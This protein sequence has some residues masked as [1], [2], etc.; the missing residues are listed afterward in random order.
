MNKLVS[1]DTFEKEQPKKPAWN[2]V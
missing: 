1:S 2:H